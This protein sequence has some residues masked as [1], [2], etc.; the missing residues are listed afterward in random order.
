MKQR[1]PRLGLAGL[2]LLLALFA[3]LPMRAASAPH[4]VLSNESVQAPHNAAA[5]QGKYSPNTMISM[6]GGMLWFTR[7]PFES[8]LLP[9]AHVDTFTVEQ[10][11]LAGMALRFTPNQ[12]GGT[13]ILIADA[14][15]NW[16]E[17]ARSGEIYPDLGP[18]LI[19]ALEQTL[20][21][22]VVEHKAPG[23][24][25]YV[26][27]P[28][29]GA[30][31]GARGLADA[32][33]GIPMVP[34]DRFRIASV[35]KT[36]VATVA[37]QL[38]EEGWLRLDDTVERWLPGL[39]PGGEQITVQQLLN[40]TSGLAD[41]MTGGFMKQVRAAPERVWKPHELVATALERPRVFAPGEP[42]RW[43]YSNTN[44][45]LAGMIIEQATRNPLEFEIQQRILTPLHL[46]DT[47]FPP[48]E[49]RVAGTARGYVGSTDYSELNMSFAWAAGG[50][51]ST[52]ADVGRFV[53]A[54]FGNELL[55]PQTLALM[56]SFASTHGSGSSSDMVYG[57][58]LM[59]RTLPDV[60]SDAAIRTVRGHTGG[61]AGYRTVMWHLPQ[62]G[63]TLV[64]AVNRYEVDPN[65]FAAA[66]L[67][68][69]IAYNA[70]PR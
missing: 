22:A 16:S 12:T 42:G 66:V 17:F 65:H 5:W 68:T 63:V 52:T 35:T 9:T 44:Y 25:L 53:Q 43:S 20:D 54:L 11:W 38:V 50:M 58:G 40:H 70:L 13:S 49:H 30:W 29:R 26:H 27:V 46:I 39:V 2:A 51:V 62:S 60:Q 18:Q 7:P 19:A 8:R 37:L 32:A 24:L 23:A 56:L 4:A 59:Q 64:V 33:H 28:G 45:I 47:G 3:A 36:F 55:K 48:P 10:G 61:L 31:L 6:R 1:F 67:N 14:A 34:L 57:L 15:G 41:Y 69:L 21:Q